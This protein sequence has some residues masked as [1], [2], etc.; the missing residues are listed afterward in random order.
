MVLEVIET[1]TAFAQVDV[2][3]PP[4]ALGPFEVQEVFLIFSLDPVFSPEQNLPDHFMI[5]ALAQIKITTVKRVF[6]DGSEF[7]IIHEE[8][9][10]FELFRGA[11]ELVISFD[12]GLGLTLA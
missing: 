3:E 5:V 7:K 8:G 4:L 10:V 12:K 2:L 6:L 11:E 9:L 1:E